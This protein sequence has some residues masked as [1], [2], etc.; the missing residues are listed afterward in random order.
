MQNGCTA[1]QFF[2]I[3]DIIAYVSRFI[4]LKSGDLVFTGTPQGV[5]AVKVGDRLTGYLDDKKM[6][7]IPIC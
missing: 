7:D 6:F 3:D 2:H 1:D 4:T 5:G